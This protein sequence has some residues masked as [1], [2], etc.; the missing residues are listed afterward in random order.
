M[1]NQHEHIDKKMFSN[2][3][4]GAIRNQ[5]LLK[6]NSPHLPFTQCQ[7]NFAASISHKTL[8]IHWFHAT[9][10]VSHSCIAIYA[11]GHSFHYVSFH[12]IFVE[13]KSWHSPCSF[14]HSTIIF[15]I[16]HP[17]F[18]S[19]THSFINSTIVQ[20]K[21]GVLLHH[22]FVLFFVW[23]ANQKNYTASMRSSHNIDMF[24]HHF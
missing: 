18:D 24:V 21:K 19:S 15:P 4:F 8:P 3:F 11:I 9:Q 10:H 20:N 14:H 2:F 1:S 6:C 13:S 7:N 5:K 16:P 17:S 22:I 12:M 23:C